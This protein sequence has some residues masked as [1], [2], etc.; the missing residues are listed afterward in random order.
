M[1]IFELTEGSPTMFKLITEG[2]NKAE[3]GRIKFQRFFFHCVV[4]T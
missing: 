2:F 1:E 4:R 3:E